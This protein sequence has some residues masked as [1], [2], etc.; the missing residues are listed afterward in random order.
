[1]WSWAGN[2]PLSE[3]VA[4]AGPAVVRPVCLPERASVAD[5]WRLTRL[6]C[7]LQASP[8]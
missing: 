3:V 5:G 2:V 4:V 1:M 8:S 7:P 6:Q